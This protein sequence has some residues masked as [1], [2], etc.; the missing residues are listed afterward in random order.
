MKNDEHEACGTEGRSPEPRLNM[1]EG[2]LSMLRTDAQTASNRSRHNA[3]AADKPRGP[4]TA[5]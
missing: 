5:F 2:M 3:K 4:E 1:R